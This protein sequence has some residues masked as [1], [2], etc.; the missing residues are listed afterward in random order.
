MSYKNAG[1]VFPHKLLC[2]IQKYINGEYIYIPRQTLKKLPWGALSGA[3]KTLQDRNREIVARKN[4]GCPVTELAKQ[5]FLS[6]K[7]IYKI[8]SAAKNG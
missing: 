7:T 5:Y 4:N 3:K 8:I 1:D 6:T 2:E